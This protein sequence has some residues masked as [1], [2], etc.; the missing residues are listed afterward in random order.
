MRAGF[1]VA[2]PGGMAS[3]NPGISTLWAFA[4][5]QRALDRVN[6]WRLSPAVYTDVSD[7]RE[8]DEQAHREHE[9]RFVQGE[10]ATIRAKAAEAPVHDA[11]EFLGWFETLERTGPGQHDRLFDW[12]E[13]EAPLE[14]MAWFLRQEVAGEA[15]FDDLV[16]LT[17]I[18]MPPRVKLEMARNYWDEM[19]QGPEGGMHGP[20]LAHLAEEMGITKPETEDVVPEALALANLLVALAVHRRYA[21]HSIGALGVVE[22]TAPGRAKRVNAGLKRLGLGGAARRYFALHSTLDVKH[23]ASWNREVLHPLVASDPRLGKAIA[24]GALM[25]L[26]AGARCFDRYRKELALA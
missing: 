26:H 16:A 22:L 15:G 25:R 10:I 12:L 13:R 9:M 4:D 21:Y 5:F 11:D 8:S 19:G 18:K 2:M 7:T 20:M 17:Q 14:A 3:S 1:A 23:S 6:R 24:E